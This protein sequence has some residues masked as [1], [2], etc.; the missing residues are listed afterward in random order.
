MKRLLTVVMI[1]FLIPSYSFATQATAQ[2]PVP[3][4]T[5]V[6]LPP[7]ATFT[8]VVQATP[9]P[10]PVP[11]TTTAGL[12][13]SGW[14][15][16]SI[17]IGAGV[18]L[19]GFAF[20]VGSIKNLKPSEAIIPFLLSIAFACVGL[21]ILLSGIHHLETHTFDELWLTIPEP[22]PLPIPE[23]TPMPV[24][25]QSSTPNAQNVVEAVLPDIQPI[26][27]L[28][29]FIASFININVFVLHLFYPKSL[30]VGLFM[31]FML[32]SALLPE[33]RSRRYRR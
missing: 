5:L 27:T 26:F 33:R 3:T 11:I 9:T 15:L 14:W 13:K 31:I 8:P 24:S 16:W 17:Y 23:P 7:T 18:V 22:P 1:L 28:D 29:I 6:S 19:F 32:I 25:G 10:I 30:G 20:I 12:V 4:E 21:M 2:E